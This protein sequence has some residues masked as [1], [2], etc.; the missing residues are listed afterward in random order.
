MLNKGLREK[1]QGLPVAVEHQTLAQ[2]LNRWLTDSVKPSVRPLREIRSADPPPRY[3]YGW[4]D[5]AGKA[6]PT[7]RTTPPE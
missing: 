4:Q 5:T 7:G 6:G 1:T 3:P 2:F